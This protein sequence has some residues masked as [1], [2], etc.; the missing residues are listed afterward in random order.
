MFEQEIFG[1]R[2]TKLTELD[3]EAIYGIPI[4][5]ML[6]KSGKSAEDVLE[7]LHKNVDKRRLIA[8]FKYDGERT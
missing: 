6:G 1:Y 5:P 3:C 2:L 8:E 7:S 4:K